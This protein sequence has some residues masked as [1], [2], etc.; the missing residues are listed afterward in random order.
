MAEYCRFFRHQWSKYAAP[1]VVTD[2]DGGPLLAQ[3]RVCKRCEA[4]HYRRVLVSNA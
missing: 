4:V 1:T 3:R 2:D